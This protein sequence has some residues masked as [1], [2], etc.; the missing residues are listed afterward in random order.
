MKILFLGDSGGS[1]NLNDGPTWTEVM[2]E[3]LAEEFHEPV[4]VEHKIFIATGEKAASIA[5]KAVE[6]HEPDLVV[7]TIGPYVFSTPF[8]W[9]RV[10]RLFGRRVG[11]WFRDIEQSFNSVTY[12]KGRVRQRINR[13]LRAVAHKVIGA[14]TITTREEST[15]VYKDTLL[16]LARTE[17]LQVMAVT[18]A[19]RRKIYQGTK[20]AEER[21]L[22]IEDVRAYAEAR[23]FLFV[24]TSPAFA[25]QDDGDGH[26]QSDG[27]HGTDGYQVIMGEF[28]TSA[29]LGHVR[30]AGR[31]TSRT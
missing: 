17:E 20:L 12:E 22:Q 7:L 27:L 3:L 16:Q 15:Q 13:V 30:E 2:R 11:H 23:H 14:E 18:N 29:Y 28:V 6:K 1:G 9:L 25:G 31:P 5:V 19:G 24:D 26:I 8:V 10:R 4:E 21:R